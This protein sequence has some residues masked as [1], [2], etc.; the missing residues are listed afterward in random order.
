MVAACLLASA[1]GGDEGGTGSLTLNISGEEAAVT[2]YP[3][4][5]D[6]EL[7]FVDGWAVK[8]DKYLV[9]VGNVRI[10]GADGKLA[11]DGEDAVIVD[12]VKGEPVVFRMSGLGARRWERFGYDI[13]PAD[14]GSRVVGAVSEADRDRMVEG[15]FNYLVEGKAKKDGR[16]LHFSW[17]LANPTR[18]HDCRNG[19]DGKP[20]VVIR[21][22]AD[23]DYQITLHLD[24]LFYDHLGD[25]KDARMRFE[26]IAAMAVQEGTGWT[27]P[28]DALVEQR[29]ANLK[30]ADGSPLVD[31]SG[32]RIFYSPGSVPL[33]DDNLRDYLLAAS[34]SQGRFNGEGSCD[35][36]IP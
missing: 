19:V 12:L 20:G 13:L 16:E 22:N 34:R 29:L 24:H 27:I 9:S 4:P 5:G 18:N 36:S 21:N 35:N 2:G 17:G 23:A 11:W 25:H 3:V 15:G 1:C 14:P 6:D 30:A 26:P 32:A 28:F 7:A 10:E 31:E 8:F 33:A